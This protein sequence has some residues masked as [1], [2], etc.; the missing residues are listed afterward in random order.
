MSLPP[1]P[2]P[3]LNVPITPELVKKH[4]LSDEE[5]EQVKKILGREPNLTEL[6]IFSVMWS[7]HCSYKNSRALLKGFPTQKSDADAPHQVLVLAGE[8]NAGVVDIGDGW[9]VCFKIESHNHPSAVEPFEG[10]A[11][12]VGG[13]IRDIFTMG[14]RPV[15]L[16]NSLRFG[17]LSSKQTQRLFRGVVHG[18]SHYGNCIGIPNVGGDIYFDSCYEGNPLVNALCLGLLRHE[19]IK[20]GAASGI[21]NPVYYVGADT[22]RDGLGGASFASKELSEES[23]ADRPAVQKGD[24][25]MEKL[26]MEACLEMMA[27]DGLV[28]GIQDMGAA[29]LTCSTCET[30]ARGNAGIEIELDK[31]PQREKDM[32]SYEIML[33]ESQERMLV[34][35]AEG[36][37]AELEAVFEKWDLHAVQIGKVTEGTDMV[38]KQHGQPVAVMPAAKLTDEAPLYKRESKEPAHL[39]EARE[40]DFSKIPV[41]GEQAL[42]E[43]LFELIGHPSI[44][45]K[46]WVWEQY[47]HMVMT[48]STI[49]PGSDAAVVRLRLGKDSFKHIAIA[50]DCNNRFCAV[51]PYKG[52]LIAVAECARNIACSG[53]RPIAMTNNLNFGN[54]EKPESFHYL[55]EAVR[56]LK[57][58]CQAFDVPV[59]GGN[60]SLYNESPESAIDPTPVVSLVGIFDREAHITQQTV[61]GG[62]S[63]ILLGGIPTELG[64]SY[65]LKVIHN[66]LVG[67][68]PEVDAEHEAHIHEFVRLQ[69]EKGRVTAAH[70]ISDGGLAVTL[71]EML[72]A[73][74][75]TFGADL[76]ISE[77]EPDRL[78][79]ALYGESQGRIVV[80]VNS[81]HE[82]K[83]LSDAEKYN[84][85]AEPLGKIMDQPWL[86]IRTESLDECLVWDA[87]ALR[88]TWERAIP[89]VMERT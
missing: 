26:L 64:C 67:D 11:T 16:T 89:D 1:N 84:I 48:G 4:G 18:I 61:S 71:A 74:D 62:E 80:A 72:F 69:I 54:P 8:E 2:D 56:G 87:N 65:Y 24:P 58:A 73:K 39:A 66:L 36:R 9:A 79:A 17:D 32:N 34:I 10:A 78:D 33:S 83:I 31:V 15:L 85:D 41:A 45:S 3:V 81:K 38:V 59:V 29:G 52:G 46:R 60:V 86:S 14:A 70:D 28:V 20:R 57:N 47:D 51:N 21:G 75:K 6:G 76:D 13:I 19:E 43:A 40:Y 50:N 82:G 49:L 27:I 68:A 63:L 42:G 37:E 35:A 77:I 44:A 7:E 30:A 88:E 23:A 12:G 53:A 25:F 5:Y 22:G 55:K